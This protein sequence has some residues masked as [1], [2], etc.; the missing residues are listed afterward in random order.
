MHAVP[1]AD[2]VV[3]GFTAINLDTPDASAR[4]RNVI[5]PVVL[6]V[7]LVILAVLLRALLAPVLLIPPWCCRSSR[8][9]RC[10]R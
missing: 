6:L 3:G 2:A 4:D 10:A 5:I 8:R 7:I 1:G 9:W